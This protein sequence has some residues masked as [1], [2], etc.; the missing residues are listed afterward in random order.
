MANPRRYLGFQFTLNPQESFP[1]GCAAALSILC[2]E[3]EGLSN[4]FL[5][6]EW[7]A[8]QFNPGFQV[9]QTK[10]VFG[11]DAIPVIPQFQMFLLQSIRCD[12]REET[13]S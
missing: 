11:M 1:I 9:W 8:Y 6:V 13:A 10:M 12:G 2:C 4:G 5:I 7:K 3:N